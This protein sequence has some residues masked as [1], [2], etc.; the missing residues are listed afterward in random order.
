MLNDVEAFRGELAQGCGNQIFDYSQKVSLV[1]PLSGDRRIKQSR[2]S[3]DILCSGEISASHH[4][5]T[6]PSDCHSA[7]SGQFTFHFL[8]LTWLFLLF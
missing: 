6:L 5:T 2:R 8:L 3:G 7:N 1:R 4:M